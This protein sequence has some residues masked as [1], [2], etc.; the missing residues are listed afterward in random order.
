MLRFITAGLVFGFLVVGYARPIM[1]FPVEI[2]LYALGLKYDPAGSQ[3][4]FSQSKDFSYNPLSAPFPN[5]MIF[6]F[7]RAKE[8]PL[9]WKQVSYSGNFLKKGEVYI[10]APDPDRSRLIVSWDQP[11]PQIY[12]YG[13]YQKGFAGEVFTTTLQNIQ[14]TRVRFPRV[15]VIQNRSGVPVRFNTAGAANEVP[16]A[17]QAPLPTPDPDPQPVEEIEAEPEENIVS[18]PIVAE[19]KP[20]KTPK[21]IRKKRKKKV[22]KKRL[23]SP[24]PTFSLFGSTAFFDENYQ[25][26]SDQA[27]VQAEPSSGLGFGGGFRWIPMSLMSLQVQADG[28]TV[29]TAENPDAAASGDT[30]TPSGE[31]SRR[32]VDAI[33]G[34]NTLFWWNSGQSHRLNLGY[35]FAS[36]LTPI[37]SKETALNFTGLVFSYMYMDSDLDIL[38]QNSS[39]TGSEKLGSSLIRLMYRLSEDWSFGVQ[40]RFRKLVG[41]SG[42]ISTDYVQ[43]SWSLVLGWSL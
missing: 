40:R 1:A 4:T 21:K 35:S 37:D 19:E 39:L 33:L 25:L 17:S 3:V 15:L 23:E 20:N 5:Q 32:F 28:N 2:P 38:L 10:I 26:E 13:F 14:A 36:T 22:Q 41:K 8:G 16:S 34:L 27:V 6:P 7:F 42:A 30:L 18:E 43:S 29:V 9:Y 11:G 31:Q 12:Q 24:F